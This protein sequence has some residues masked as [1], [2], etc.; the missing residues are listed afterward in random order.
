MTL[1]SSMSSAPAGSAA[2]HVPIFDQR[3]LQPHACHPRLELIEIGDL[4][5]KIARHDRVVRPGR[6]LERQAH[7]L[8]DPPVEALH[9]LAKLLIADLKEIERHVLQHRAILVDA[10]LFHLDQKF[11]L[12]E[13]YRMRGTV[14]RVISAVICAALSGDQP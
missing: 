1:M 13:V 2:R 11:K 6:K 10:N 12:V 4:L 5:S 9:V 8:E 3:T 7:E 14:P